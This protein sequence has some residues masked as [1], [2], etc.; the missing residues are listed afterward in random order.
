MRVAAL[1]GLRGLAILLVVGFHGGWPG[2]SWGDRGVD[3]FFV[4]SGYLVT[5]GVLAERERTARF[6][7]GAFLARRALRLIPALAVFLVGYTALCF[8]TFTDFLP[9]LPL[10]LLAAASFT[11]NVAIGWFGADLL[12]PHTWALA[13]EVQFYLLY[14]LLAARLERRTALVATAIL[15]AAA[16][17]WR[18]ALLLHGGDGMPVMRIGFSPDT[19]GDSVLWG[20]ALALWL[21]SAG[22]AGA[23][24]LA[25]GAAA[26]IA[27]GSFVGV[28][29]AS[30]AWPGFRDVLGH[31]LAGL[32][33]AALLAAIECGPGVPAVRALGWRPL[34]ALGAVSYPLYLW[35]PACLGI[36]GRIAFRAP[37]QWQGE[38]RQLCYVALSIA[39][40][41]G[42]SRFVE[43]PFLRIKERYSR[44]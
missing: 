38:T 22:C 28:A 13:L 40:A 33:L 17:L 37:A 25:R 14:P 20:C 11:S 2:F 27:A 9:R 5:R 18:G 34:L 21:P 31:S 8:T 41:A 32:T 35:H 43:R 42:S 39:A 10:S 15:L 3:V 30:A 23:R 29:L 26:G 1:D 12:L 7:T 24:P 6:D 16:L 19:R 44:A 36:A 4:L